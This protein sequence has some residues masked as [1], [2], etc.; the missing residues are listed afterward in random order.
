MTDDRLPT[1]LWV[2]AHLHHI[3]AEGG[4]YYIINKGA[5][6]SGTV[7]LKISNMQGECR[8]MQQQRDLDGE[9]GWMALFK[10]EVVAEREADDYIRRAIDRDPDLWAIE[11]ENKD[12]E[13]PFEGKVF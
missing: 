9:M 11:I 3:T 7:L 13:S 10:G 1:E 8:V 6:A 4:T 5:L 12:M 2:D